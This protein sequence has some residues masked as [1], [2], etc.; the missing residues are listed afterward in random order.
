MISD[1][2]AIR[3]APALTRSRISAFSNF[4]FSFS[5]VLPFLKNFIHLMPVF[6][7]PFF[8][9]SVSSTISFMPKSRT[10]IHSAQLLLAD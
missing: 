3:D 1:L 9:S 6:S 5:S 10:H 2:L 4:S 8:P 7:A